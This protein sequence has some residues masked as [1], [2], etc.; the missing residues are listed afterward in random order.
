MHT[1][2]THTLPMFTNQ[3]I[4]IYLCNTYAH[5]TRPYEI[6]HVHFR[7]QMKILLLVASIEKKAYACNTVA[8]AVAQHTMV[9]Q[10]VRYLHSFMHMYLAVKVSAEKLDT[11]FDLV[12]LVWH[13]S[14]IHLLMC[15]HI[16]RCHNHYS[17]MG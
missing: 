4:I 11:D 3:Q 5:T 2:W 8:I 13:T 9:T 17:I 10:L 1:R 14:I 7:T 12:F 16:F 6:I 15:V